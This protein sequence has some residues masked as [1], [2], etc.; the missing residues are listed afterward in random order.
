L[1]I[2]TNRYFVI[3]HNMLGGCQGTTGPSSLAPDGKPWGSRFP[4][5]TVEDMVDIQER[6][7]AALGIKELYA[8]AGG[9][10]GG[11]VALE[12]ARRSTGQAK[13]PVRKAFITAS[14]CAHGAMQIGFNEAARQAIFRDPNY[15]GGDYYEGEPPR[16][17]LSVARM[18]GH[19]SYLSSAAFD[20]KFGRR[21][22]VPRI[23][24]RGSRGEVFEVESYLSYQGDKFT[25]RFDANSLVVLSSAIDAYSCE[26][27]EGCQTE[28]CVVSFTSDW[29]YPSSLSAALHELALKHGCKSNWEEIDMPWGH[30]SF[31]LD[32]EV[33]GE[34][35]RKFLG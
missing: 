3:G 29:I 26:S 15:N 30:D 31:L 32:G 21:R 11:M 33:Q 14:A 18:V 1:A 34:I 9:S 25:D 24:D 19:L 16:D 20:L 13:I 10:M 5:V 2:D 7:V 23:Q 22:Q 17:G 8:V 27:L 28:F 4:K 35:V 12:W 6:F